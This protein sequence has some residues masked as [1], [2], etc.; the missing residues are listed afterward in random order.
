M[1]DDVDDGV[2]GPEGGEVVVE[3]EKGV[4]DVVETEKG[5]H[6]I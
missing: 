4:G 6:L 5:L 1:V 2:F 3:K